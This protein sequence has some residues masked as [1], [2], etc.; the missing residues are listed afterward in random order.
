MKAVIAIDSFKGSLSSMD[1]HKA[2]GRWR[3]G[4]CRGFDR[5]NEW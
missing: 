3:R 4:N 2:T 5:W 1:C